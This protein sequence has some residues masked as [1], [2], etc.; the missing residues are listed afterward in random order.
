MPDL[1]LGNYILALL[2]LWI[3]GIAFSFRGAGVKTDYLPILYL[4][5]TVSKFRG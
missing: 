3:A 5:L 2:L 4:L 1:Q